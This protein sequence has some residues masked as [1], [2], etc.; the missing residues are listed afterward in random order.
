MVTKWLKENKKQI[1]FY[2]I[3]FFFIL[4]FSL[5]TNNYDYD[6][7]A[8][9]I[10]GKY[11]IQTG[12]VLKQDFLSYTP[13]HTIYDH[14]W[15]SG[16][17]FYLVNHYFS[18]VGL[19]FLQ[20]SILFLIFFIIIQIIKLRGV[21]TT[22]PYNFLFYFFSFLAITQ[23]V[24][25]PIRCQIFS[26]LFFTVFMYILE[27]SRKGINKPLWTMPFIMIIWNNLH[28]GCVAGIGLI[29][30]Y[31]IGEI[32]NRKPVKKYMLTF[33]LTILVLPINPW[34]ISYLIFLLKATTMQRTHIVE[35]WGLFCPVYKKIFIEFKF[36]TLVLLLAEI[37]YI[38]K[39][40]KD[41]S[42]VFDAV[43][44]LAIIITLVLGIWHIKLIPFCVISMTAF[45][46]DDF[47]TFFNFITFNILNKFAKF[48]DIFIYYII[49]IFI[50]ININKKNFEP[51]LDWYKFPI[52]AI[53]F[54]KINEIKGNLFVNFGLGS[55]ASYK[56]YPNNKIFIDGRYE[57]VYYDFMMPM[58]QRFLLVQKNWDDL[59]KYYPP[60]LLL[61][62]K[63]YPVYSVLSKDPY[64]TQI[65]VNEQF[66][67]FIKST[68]V[69]KK[70]KLPSP[71]LKHYKKTLFDTDIDFMIKS[72]SE[73]K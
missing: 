56:L 59:L 49:I 47:Y 30:I 2:V 17:I 15:G 61:I 12:H 58:M 45:L 70:Y 42:F 65:F 67:L 72:K 68:K 14:E 9:L 22:T 11:F 69:K 64:W 29:L 38:I 4:A 52:M 53:E 7:W 34:G 35:W 10:V 73:Q 43:K 54:I 28:G 8:R 13:T 51:F 32:I 33:L 21:K 50:F 37:G 25:Q 24:D 40:T 41:K 3:F 16:V 26:F 66:G 1:F 46:Y 27:L 63:I 18:H 57:E 19:L 62:E 39:A 23:V 55:Y 6:L 5:T 36:F 60:D 44:Y 71:F 20:V 48:K 31:I